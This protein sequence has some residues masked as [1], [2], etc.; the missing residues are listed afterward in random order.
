MFKMSKT[1]NG[2][3]YVNPNTIAHHV[4]AMRMGERDPGN[5]PNAND[6][7]SYVHVVTPMAKG[8]KVLQGDR[9]E[10][11]EYYLNNRATLEIDYEHYLIRQVMNPITSIYDL[12]QPGIKPEVL[13]RQ[14]LEKFKNRKLGVRDIHITDAHQTPSTAS[15]TN[16]TTTTTDD[17]QMH[18][19][20]NNSAIR[21]LKSGSFLKIRAR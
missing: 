13:F 9:I 8:E 20:R 6:R 2:G 12:G 3:N 21:T 15:T 11:T 4:L 16:T 7:I 1:W 10:S 5:R 17:G 14:I 19:V 18:L